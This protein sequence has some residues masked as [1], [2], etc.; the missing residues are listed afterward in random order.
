MKRVGTILENGRVVGL[1]HGPDAYDQKIIVNGRV[2]RFDFD[3]WMGPLWI[4][5]DG[6]ARENQNPGKSVWKEFEKWQ[7]RWFRMQRSSD[8]DKP[9]SR[10]REIGQSPNA[11]PSATPNP[12]DNHGS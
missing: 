6:Q 11:L 1:V 3:K 2:W 7:K 10:R 4:R 9:I 12:E 8:A 5:K